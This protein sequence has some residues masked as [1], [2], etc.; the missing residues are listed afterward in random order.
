[1]SITTKERGWA[2]HFILAERCRFRR[3]TLVSDGNR[4]IV[5]S[6]VGACPPQAIT[7]Q[8][9]AKMYAIG[10]FGRVFETMAF[11]AEM[12]DGYLDADVMQTVH[13]VRAPWSISL[14]DLTVIP[15]GIDNDANDMH[16]AYVADVVANFDALYTN[17]KAEAES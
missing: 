8:P 12:Q 2:G 9:D 4:H 3:N 1:M 7:S 17:A 15:K 11:V 5:V 16:D 10:A 13:G 6:T 14:D